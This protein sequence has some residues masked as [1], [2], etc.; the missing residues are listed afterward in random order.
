MITRGINATAVSHKLKMMGVSDTSVR[1]ALGDTP[2]TRA[3]TVHVQRNLQAPC[4][5]EKPLQGFTG[6]VT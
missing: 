2:R 3:T 4:R 1:E 6:N 5:D